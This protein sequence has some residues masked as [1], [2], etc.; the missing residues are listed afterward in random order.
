MADDEPGN[1]QWD[2]AIGADP[3]GWIATQLDQVEMIAHE[4]GDL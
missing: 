4:P 2:P 3:L 1:R